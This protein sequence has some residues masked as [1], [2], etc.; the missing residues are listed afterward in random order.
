MHLD[1]RQIRHLKSFFD[2]KTIDPIHISAT[3]TIVQ[4]A[5]VGKVVNGTYTTE[6]N[7]WCT[8]EF[9]D[10]S[11]FS[12]QVNAA[13]KKVQTEVENLYKVSCLDYEIHFLK[14]A[15]GAEYKSHIDGQLIANNVASRA[16][17]RDITAVIYLNEDYRGGV[18]HF[19]LFD[20][21]YTPKKGDVL[22]YPTTYEYVHHVSKVEGI[23][24]AI[25]IW[26]RTSP[27]LNVTKSLDQNTAFYL[28]RLINYKD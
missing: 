14:Y 27:E 10:Y 6:Y 25:V 24:Y 17:N 21:S 9:V 12:D 26:F 2:D 22:I 3:K 1:I 13:I 7:K 18:L 16:V 23:R 20:L 4:P 28:Q 5:T 19:D 8:A 15:D 11:S